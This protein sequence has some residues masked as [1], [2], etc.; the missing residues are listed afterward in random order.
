MMLKG[1]RREQK[2]KRRKAKHERTN[3]RAS[4]H[5]EQRLQWERNRREERQYKE[6][7][8]DHTD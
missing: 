7:E 2:R 1:V 6:R 4:H 8:R 5:L 3:N